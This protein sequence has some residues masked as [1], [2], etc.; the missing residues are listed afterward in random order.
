MGTPVLCVDSPDGMH[1][2]SH[3]AVAP[4]HGNALEAPPTQPCLLLGAAESRLSAQTSGPGAGRLADLPA[5][6]ACECAICGIQLSASA[7][8]RCAA[9][10]PRRR[11]VRV[12]QHHRRSRTPVL[13]SGGAA[14]RRRSRPQTVFRVMGQPRNPKYGR[15]RRRPSVGSQCRK[16]PHNAAG[17]RRCGGLQLPCCAAAPPPLWSSTKPRG[18]ARALESSGGVAGRRCAALQPQRR[19]STGLQCQRRGRG[20]VDFRRCGSVA[21]C[22]PAGGR[23]PLRAR[24]GTGSREGCR[25]GRC[26]RRPAS[27]TVP[28]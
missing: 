22:R 11:H 4:R 17:V 26:P 5:A 15:S 13:T 23:P 8:C 6:A 14:G 18:A 20:C 7:A 12:S 3:A 1:S 10:Q 21:A 28:L 19:P 9:A 27:C 25:C 2:R 16:R 24:A